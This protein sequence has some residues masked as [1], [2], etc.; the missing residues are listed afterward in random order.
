MTEALIPSD[1]EHIV[2][3]VCLPRKQWPVVVSYV[4]I[5][6]SVQSRADQVGLESSSRVSESSALPRTGFQILELKRV[7]SCLVNRK[8]H[9]LC[10][11][12]PWSPGSYL[13]TGLC[14]L[15]NCAE[16]GRI[17]TPLPHGLE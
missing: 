2:K 16:P 11:V 7:S 6:S 4:G 14:V 9:T 1:K 13:H 12:L 15:Q 5:A 17:L 3:A 8:P 10:Y